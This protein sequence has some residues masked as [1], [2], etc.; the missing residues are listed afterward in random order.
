MR[1]N[2][3]ISLLTDWIKNPK[4]KAVSRLISL[5]I[6]GLLMLSLS[7][8]LTANK[9]EY[10]NISSENIGNEAEQDLIIKELSYE[11]KLEKQLSEL[12]HQVKDV[13]DVEIM[14]TLE[15]ESSVEPAFNIAST[16][17]NSEEKDNEGGVRTIVEK[18]TNTQLVLLKKNGEEQPL[19]LKKTTPK[20]KGILIIADGAFSS[21]V[22]EKIIKSTATLFDIPIYKI[23]VL[24]K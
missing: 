21:K 11:A 7:K 17:K 14:I 23:S 6:L 10:D 12:L 16:E 24:E 13:G 20:I 8:L 1:P 18:Q 2:L 3:N 4:N 19:I 15:D 5:F 9:N 22:R